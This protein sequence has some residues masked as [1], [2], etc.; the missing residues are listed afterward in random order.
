MNQMNELINRL[1]KEPVQVPKQLAASIMDSLPDRQDDKTPR[2]RNT[3]TW[4]VALRVVS[5]T[6]AVLCLLIGFSCHKEP[7]LATSHT[8][9]RT[10]YAQG[11]TLDIVRTNLQKQH[12]LSYTSIKAMLNENH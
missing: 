8:P 4:L 3:P 7:A 5:T 11:N 10:V 1:Q 2:R 9:N 6:A 12:N